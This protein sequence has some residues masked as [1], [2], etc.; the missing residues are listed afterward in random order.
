MQGTEERGE[1]AHWTRLQWVYPQ[2]EAVRASPGT[3]HAGAPK[4]VP[5]KAQWTSLPTG[6]TNRPK[7]G[8]VLEA[9]SNEAHKR[10]ACGGCS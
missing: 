1:E 10:R 9:Q 2:A 7:K 3:L 4:R 5:P 8:R 6:W